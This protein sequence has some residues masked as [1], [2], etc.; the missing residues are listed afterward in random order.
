MASL[1][2]T[3]TTTMWVVDGVHCSTANNRTAAQ[4]AT[5]ASLTNL[6]VFVFDIT[7][8]TN[9]RS[10]ETMYLP[11]LARRQTQEDVFAFLRHNLCVSTG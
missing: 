5:T 2:A 11:K 8:L 1:G 9:G 6:P 10:T 4:P 3:L 7:D